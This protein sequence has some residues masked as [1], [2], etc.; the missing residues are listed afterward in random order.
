MKLLGFGQDQTIFTLLE[1]QA[2]AAG[3]AARE[4]HAMTQD[5]SRFE[6]HLARIDELEHEADDLT[7]QLANKV[8]ATFVT[9]LDK[10]DLHAI[11]TALDDIT[12]AIEDATN[13][14]NLYRMPALR[15][16]I[17]PL[18]TLLVEIMSATQEAIGCLRTKTAREAMHPIFLRIHDLEEQADNAHLSALSALFHAPDRDPFEFISWKEIYD[19][20]ETAVDLCEDVTNIVESIVVKYA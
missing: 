17:E 15:P 10:E 9:P 8:D 18:A 3:K 11:S 6:Q 16:D 1:G 7:H 5:Y 12:D 19:G 2:E 4:F 20:I 14:I 13:T